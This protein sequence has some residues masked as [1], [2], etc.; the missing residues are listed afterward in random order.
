MSKGVERLK[1]ALGANIADSIRNDRR[2]GSGGPPPS[3]SPA[4]SHRYQGLDRIKGALAIPLNRLGADPDQPRKEFDPE[5]LDHLARSLKDR[6]QLMPARVRWADD[7]GR[8]VIVAGERR[9]RAAARAGLPTLL[10]VEAPGGLTPDEVLDEQL[11]ENCVREDL[12]PVEQARAFQALMTRRGWSQRQLADHLHVSQSKVQKALALLDLPE[13]IRADVDTGAIAPST[14]YELTKVPDPA[15]Q[16]ALAD[17]ARAGGLK[18]EAAR[19]QNRPNPTR[20]AYRVPGGHVA[21]TL[22]DPAAP[23][24]AVVAALKAALRLAEQGDAEGRGA[25]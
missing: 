15:R 20:A 10:C 6:G 8:W 3:S 16:A 2:S 12:K 13:P 21:V 9:F 1:G 14:A 11:T 23:H 24:L 22:D 25:A 18:R 19:G 4:S 17:A 5:A 7:L